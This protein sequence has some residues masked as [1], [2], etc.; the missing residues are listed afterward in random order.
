VYGETAIIT[1]YYKKANALES[2][3]HLLQG[4][5]IDPENYP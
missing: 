4:Y 1:S 2:I 3:K 5:D